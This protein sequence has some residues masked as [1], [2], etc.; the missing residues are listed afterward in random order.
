MMMTEGQTIFLQTKIVLLNS[1]L[2]NQSKFISIQAQYQ[3]NQGILKKI[4]FV[5]D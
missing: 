2:K 4:K 3:L 5:S 1:T